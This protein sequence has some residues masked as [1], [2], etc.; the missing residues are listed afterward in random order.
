MSVTV[1]AD[2]GVSTAA[3]E[4][5]KSLP[6]AAAPVMVRREVSRP[7]N[8]W[9]AASGSAKPAGTP[10]LSSSEPADSGCSV[11]VFV[12]SPG[13]KTSCVGVVLARCVSDRLMGTVTGVAPGR[14]VW[15][16]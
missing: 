3:S 15:L 14:S 10:R 1:W 16:E 9:R 12:P 4:F 11:K 8:V 5:C 6:M 7:I 13:L 2:A